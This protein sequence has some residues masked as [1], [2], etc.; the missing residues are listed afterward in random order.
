MSSQLFILRL[1]KG[2]PFSQLV[3]RNQFREMFIGNCE[4][5][6]FISYHFIQSSLSSYLNS[7]P[8]E[9]CRLDGFIHLGV[10][11][12]QLFL[13][14]CYADSEFVV[15]IHWIVM[16]LGRPGQPEECAQAIAFLA[17]DA[18]SFITG[19]TLPVDGGRH[20]LCPR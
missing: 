10:V 2:S 8:R 13:L 15:C 7:T 5:Y 4:L 6:K 9:N 16:V 14:F 19:A 3:T 11:S 12:T 18:A 20:A 1:S 17:S